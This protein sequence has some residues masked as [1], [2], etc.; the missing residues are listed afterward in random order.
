MEDKTQK[1]KIREKFIERF[2][3]CPTDFNYKGDCYQVADWWLEQFD[4][5]IKETE[6]RVVRKERDN[7]LGLVVRN[8]QGFIER[9]GEKLWQL[10]MDSLESDLLTNLIRNK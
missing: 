8:C 4:L 5:A 2:Y 10:D 3:Q 7:L 6:E 1:E 9:D